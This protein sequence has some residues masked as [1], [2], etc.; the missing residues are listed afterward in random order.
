MSSSDISVLA[1]PAAYDLHSRKQHGV[2]RPRADTGGDRG[3]AG[4]AQKKA[5]ARRRKSRSHPPV[6]R[7]WTLPL[8]LILAFLAVYAVNPTESNPVHPFIFLSYPLGNDGAV[9]SPSQ[10][11]KGLWDL[12]FVFFYTIVISFFR[13]FTMHEVLRPLAR[14]Y[15][16]TSRNK[17]ARFNEQMYTAAYTAFSGPLGLYVMSRS[18]LWYFDTR[19][20]YEGY[21]HMSHEAVF[22]FYYLFQAA[23][24]AQQV[25]VMVLGLEKRRKDFK[26]FVA[27]HIVTVSLIGLSYKFHFTY[28]G[29]GIYITHDI[30]DFFLAT[31]KALNY[32]DSPL[33]GPYFAMCIGWWIYLRHYLN[34]RVLYSI[35]TEFATIG[36]YHLDWA[37][38]QYK[39]WISHAVTFGLL[40]ALQALNL[41][42]LYCLGRVAYRFVVLNIAKDDRSEDEESEAEAA[43]D[44]EPIAKLASSLKGSEGV[45]AQTKM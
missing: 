20:M 32:I 1:G 24:W 17:Q 27:H 19:A 33:Q 12:A 44:D 38:E 15:G 2:T 7:T 21:P 11:G 45:A 39:C 29:V 43:E 30:S 4:D 23:F 41:F 37:A 16:I 35:L 22:K 9:D 8:G 3:A 36:P 42:W 28:M 6:L 13:E 18:P 34:L 31:S 5:A 25:L 14:A 26:E 40:A 10:Y